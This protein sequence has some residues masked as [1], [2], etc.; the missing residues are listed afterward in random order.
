MKNLKSRVVNVLGNENGGPNV[1][2]IMGIAVA[3]AVG[4]GL[5]I[6]G[7]AV[8]DW[9]N[10]SAGATVRSIETPSAGKFKLGRAGA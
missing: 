10:G 5:F 6:F 3:L 8:F 9:F 7:G 4:V 1:E 2:Q